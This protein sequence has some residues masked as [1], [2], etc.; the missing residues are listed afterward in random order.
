M[1]LLALGVVGMAVNLDTADKVASVL[2]T[3]AALTGL[4][5]TAHGLLFSRRKPDGPLGHGHQRVDQIH[6][7]ATIDIVD[8]VVGDVRLGVSPMPSPPP[9]GEKVDGKSA[10]LPALGEQS[11]SN[12][13]AKGPVRIVRGV[14]GDL[15]VGA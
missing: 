15:D 3:I 13:R 12:V 1:A 8:T 14:N 6:S 4:G 9:A 2:G 7:G 5:L 10:E 11:V